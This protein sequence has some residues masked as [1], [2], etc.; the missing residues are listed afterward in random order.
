MQALLRR[1][2][3]A[4]KDRFDELLGVAATAVGPACRCASAW[5][6]AANLVPLPVYCRG[7]VL[8]RPYD[9]LR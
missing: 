3:S 4:A 1:H 5:T 9:T 2:L 8:L 6:T 7:S